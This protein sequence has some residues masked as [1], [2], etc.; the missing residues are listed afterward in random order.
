MLM[1]FCY[2]QVVDMKVL[3][4]RLW[5]CERFLVSFRHIPQGSVLLVIDVCLLINISVISPEVL[6]YQ[7][8]EL[9]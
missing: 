6:I 2:Q 7:T 3:T 1:L 9:F 4:Q 5:I 8:P